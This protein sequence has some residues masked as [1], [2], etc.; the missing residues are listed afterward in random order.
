[1]YNQAFRQKDSMIRSG[2]RKDFH[3]MAGQ[4]DAKAHYETP[5]A[6]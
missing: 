1:M 4:D 5:R 6:P 3:H 2:L